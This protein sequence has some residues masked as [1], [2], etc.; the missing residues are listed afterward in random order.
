[1]KHSIVLVIFL[2]IVFFVGFLSGSLWQ[3]L[4]QNRLQML[5]QLPMT[6]V[7]PPTKPTNISVPPNSGVKEDAENIKGRNTVTSPKLTEEEQITQALT[8]PDFKRVHDF[9]IRESPIQMNLEN[10]DK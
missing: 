1:M 9:L 4:L 2:F 5:P 6:S 10:K 7:V 3:A 8:D